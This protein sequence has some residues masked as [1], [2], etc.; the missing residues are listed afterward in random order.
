MY[1]NLH[2]LLFTGLDSH[3]HALIDYCCRD[4][5]ML[6]LQYASYYCCEKHV[7]QTYTLHKATPTSQSMFLCL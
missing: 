4:P 2:K 3:A 5:G 7:N 6:P 1:K